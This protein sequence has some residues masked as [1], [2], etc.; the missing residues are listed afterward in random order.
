MSGPG[1]RFEGRVAVVTGGANG[2]GLAV[3]SRLAGEGAH[4]ACWDIDERT[5]LFEWAGLRSSAS[6]RT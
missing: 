3:A 4:V 5:D 1:A 2:I 6:A